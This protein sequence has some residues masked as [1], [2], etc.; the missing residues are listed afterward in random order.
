VTPDPHPISAGSISHGMPVRRT[1]K[2][3]VSAARAGIGGRPPLGLGG[4]HGS[5]GSMINHSESGTRG[6]RIP[7]HESTPTRVQGF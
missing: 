3:P 4:G 5:N 1:N 7:S 2:M 6:L